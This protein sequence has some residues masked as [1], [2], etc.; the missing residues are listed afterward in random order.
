[1]QNGSM[2]APNSLAPARFW[3][4]LV[5]FALLTFASAG[6]ARAQSCNDD[7]AKL[8]QKRGAQIEALNG[9]A[10]A[11]KGKL[12]PIAACPRFRELA[13]IEEQ[14][15]AYL[16]KNKDWCNIPDEFLNNF[17]TGSAKSAGMATQ[18][19]AIAAKI[20]KMQKEQALG[21]GGG[22]GGN[23][24]PAPKLPAGPL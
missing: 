8:G 22:G 1:M 15:L 14:M 18:A 2:K 16:T 19:C 4:L 13:S 11:N 24:G 3:L 20:K 5:G 9:I 21:G 23:L 10:K 7:L 12:D 17:K 6:G